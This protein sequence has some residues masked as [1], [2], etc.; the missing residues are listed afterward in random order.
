MWRVGRRHD[1]CRAS[2][3]TEG[4]GRDG[5]QRGGRAGRRPRAGSAGDRV[6]LLARGR[7]GLE[8]A[9]REVEAAG[10]PEAVAVATDVSDAEAVE[11][12]ASTVDEELGPVDVWVNNAMASVF[13]PVSRIDAD[14]IRRVTEVTY[15]G[16]VN[17]TLAALERMRARDRGTLVFV[18]SSLALRGIPGQA[19]YCGAKHA[20]EGFRDS[21]RAELRAENSNVAL[22]TVNLPAV[23]TPQFSW[24]RNRLPR[25]PQ[26]MPPIFQPEVAARAVAWAAD[27]APR[28]L[29][30]GLPTL[31]V[32]WANR[33]APAL[34]DRYL[35]ATGLDDQQTDEPVGERPDNLDVPLDDDVDFGARGRFGERAHDRSGQLWV[36][37]HKP[38]LSVAGAALA[39]AAAVLARRR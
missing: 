35:G 11:A 5:C 36:A 24:V 29:D 37:T 3:N 12:A 20:I 15:L 1:T 14:E 7:A 23:N 21:L 31:L 9:R 34:L 8:A 33:L 18:G 39:A 10:A 28:E 4:R 26:P 25:H 30:V 27:H 13:A 32:R 17:G 19:A 22:T 38:G 2:P 6:A 16:Y